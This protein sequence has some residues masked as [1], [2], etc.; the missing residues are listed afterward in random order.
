MTARA[1]CAA[2]AGR[3]AIP[4]GT[5]VAGAVEA[6][7]MAVTSIWRRA[8]GVY[9]SDQAF[10]V[11]ANLAAVLVCVLVVMWLILALAPRQSADALLASESG[12]SCIYFAGECW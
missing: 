7:D 6:G 2:Y 11:A 8:W 10:G 1:H 3:E 5:K 9:S 12:A 4:G